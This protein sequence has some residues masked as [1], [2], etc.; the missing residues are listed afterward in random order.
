MRGDL[1]PVS[2]PPPSTEGEEQAYLLEVQSDA[3]DTAP[4]TIGV[5][6]TT[7][8]PAAGPPLTLKID[9][10]QLGLPGPLWVRLTQVHT[11]PRTQLADAPAG[12]IR[13]QDLARLAR[14]LAAILGLDPPQDRRPPALR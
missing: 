5:L 12:R 8:P 6:A 10:Q 3:L 4:T 9:G 13:D 2:V 1:W 11:R 14:P 7:T